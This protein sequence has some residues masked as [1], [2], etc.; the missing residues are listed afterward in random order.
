MAA[1]QPTP[2]SARIPPDVPSD[3]GISGLLSAY[4]RNFSLWCRD[5]FAEQIR[6]NQAQ[7]GV[8]L[9]GYDM[10]A[11]ENPPV[12]MLEASVSGT[13]AL[14]P[15]ALG[16]GKVG[17]PQ[18]VHSNYFEGGIR[19]DA[20][21]STEVATQY[22]QDGVMRWY[23]GA[24][25]A[26]NWFLAFCDDAGQYRG[27]SILADRATGAVSMDYGLTSSSHT[28]LNGGFSIGVGAAATIYNSGGW[29]GQAAQC[30]F[31]VQS[32]GPGNSAMM[33][34][35][36]AGEF[37]GQF[38][39]HG[40]A[41]LHFGGWSW[42]EG[43]WYQIWSSIDFANPA[44]DYRFKDAVAPLDSTWDHVKALRPIKYRQKAFELPATKGHSLIEADDRER[45]G[46]IAHELQETLGDTAA[47]CPKD[48]PDRLQA[49]NLMMLVA[50]LTKTVQEMQARIEELE[51]R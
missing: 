29:I 21:P 40:D 36:C 47:H 26:S 17:D 41:R 44:C 48:D 8:M 31:M 46:F 18:P 39:L 15:M 4:L 28:N 13:L 5:G 30:N 50:A 3:P 10:P 43:A 20:T 6:N 34:F 7:R 24:N 9:L 27:T 19:L 37:A 23:T 25:T 14:A 51:A 49:P 1:Q 12:W 32:A 22:S 33:T 38:G 42:G 11:G 2:Q 16:S 35:H 45:W